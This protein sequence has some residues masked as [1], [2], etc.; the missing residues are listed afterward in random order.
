M[1]AALLRIP[2]VV[3]PFS[4]VMEVGHRVIIVHDMLF[5][6]TVPRRCSNYQS[7]DLTKP[8]RA[9]DGIFGFGQHG[10]SVVSQLPPKSFNSNF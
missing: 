4:M 1:V 6:D 9:D 7:G 8:D 5:F 2:S 10:L 3:T